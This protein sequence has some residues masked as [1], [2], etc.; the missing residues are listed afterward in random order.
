MGYMWSIYDN[1][2]CV[3][4]INRGCMCYLISIGRLARV[5]VLRNIVWSYRHPGTIDK[6]KRGQADKQELKE[7][8][9]NKKRTNH[10]TALVLTYNGNKKGIN[11]R[12]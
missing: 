5:Y 1:E 6:A 8:S 9:S 3:K 4:E 11:C 12:P 2:K 7:R 10:T